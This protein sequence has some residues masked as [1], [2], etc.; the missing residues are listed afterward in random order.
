[1]S[2]KERIL[3]RLVRGDTRAT[4]IALARA[5]DVSIVTVDKCLRRLEAEGKIA[6]RR[7]GRNREIAVRS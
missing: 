4:N 1:M 7:I 5:V 3:A 6:R 2:A